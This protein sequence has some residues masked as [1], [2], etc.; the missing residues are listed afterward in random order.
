MKFPAAIFFLFLWP[1]TGRLPFMDVVIGIDPGATSG[2]AVLTVE[3]NPNLLLGDSITWPKAGTKKDLSANTPSSVVKSLVESMRQFGHTVVGAAI[4][5]QFLKLNVN[6]MK[7][8]ARNS[9]RW[10]E[11]CRSQDIPVVW[12]NPATW[13]AKELGSS[14]IDSAEVKRRCARKVVGIWNQRL[15]Q[16][17]ADAAIIGRYHA[18]RLAFVRLRGGK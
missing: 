5:D 6:T 3:G 4:E 2:W 16:D 10:E 1:Q 9:G 15:K 17:A 12:V 8:I 7:K 13:Q 11:A 18:I 14:R